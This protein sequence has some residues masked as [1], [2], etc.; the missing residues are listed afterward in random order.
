MALA[1]LGM[2]LGEF[3]L[4]RRQAWL[5]VRLGSMAA[6]L[7]GFFQEAEPLGGYERI[8]LYGVPPVVCFLFGHREGTAWSSLVLLGW[9]GVAFGPALQGTELPYSSSFVARFSFSY[10]IISLLAFEVEWRRLG[11]RLRLSRET[12]A[13]RRAL[14]DVEVLQGFVPICAECKSVR[15]DR[16]YWSEIGAYLEEHSLAQVREALCAECRAMSQVGPQ[17]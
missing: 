15:D 3:R 14:R 4:G 11:Y 2:A 1:A 13:L 7:L 8:W 12:E 16:G 9:L 17:P 6:I 5:W 10:V